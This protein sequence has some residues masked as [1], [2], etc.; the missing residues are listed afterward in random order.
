VDDVDVIWS[1]IQL[2]MLI[3]VMQVVSVAD[4][5]YLPKAPPLVSGE[6]V[7][8]GV[9]HYC[10]HCNIM[11]P[12]RS[13]HDFFCTMPNDEDAAPGRCVVKYDHYCPF[14]NNAVGVSNER[15]FLLFLYIAAYTIYK[16]MQRVGSVICQSSKLCDG[17]QILT[18]LHQGDHY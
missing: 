17:V 7:S 18:A 9:E 6:E 2:V 12:L 13:K 10:K 1:A 5:G 4:P 8:E 14:I 11:Q 15:L 3:T 16:H